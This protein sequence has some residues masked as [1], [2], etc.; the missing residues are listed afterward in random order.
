MWCN[1]QDEYRDNLKKL[2]GE[3]NAQ[4]KEIFQLIEDAYFAGDHDGYCEGQCNSDATP[5]SM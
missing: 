3:N 2:I 4:F 5:E 1:R